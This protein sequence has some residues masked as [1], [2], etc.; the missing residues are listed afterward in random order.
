MDQLSLT[1]HYLNPGGV[2]G[3]WVITVFMGQGRI[4]MLGFLTAEASEGYV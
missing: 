3:H 1:D 2:E 4:C